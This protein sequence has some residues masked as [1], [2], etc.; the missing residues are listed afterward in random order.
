MLKE[1]EV[2]LMLENDTDDLSVRWKLP[3][4]PVWK[5]F[6]EVRDTGRCAVLPDT[7]LIQF[8]DDKSWNLKLE[9]TKKDYQC[10]NFQHYYPLILLGLVGMIA[11]IWSYFVDSGLE[12]FQA[13]RT[14]Y[15]DFNQSFD[16]N[17]EAI[18]QREFSEEY[19][20]YRGF[21]YKAD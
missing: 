11:V 12:W 9:I 8:T 3:L 21:Y 13:M 15:P 2:N 7:H 20:G 14:N 18:K 19:I 1:Y 4:Q 17:E 5:G 6:D 16:K 10:T